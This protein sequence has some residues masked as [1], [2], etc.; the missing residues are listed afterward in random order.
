MITRPRRIRTRKPANRSSFKLDWPFDEVSD[1][2]NEGLHFVHHNLHLH[3]SDI[4]MGPQ[5][6][7]QQE[8]WHLNT[9]YNVGPQIFMADIFFCSLSPVIHSKKLYSLL[10]F[11]DVYLQ[12]TLCLDLRSCIHLCCHAT[13]CWLALWCH[14]LAWMQHW[15]VLGDWKIFK[16]LYQH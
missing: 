10:F 14:Q 13:A 9:L 6:F 15:T 12:R 2:Q 1:H 7:L 4:T 5:T 3:Y 8:G 16:K 11:W